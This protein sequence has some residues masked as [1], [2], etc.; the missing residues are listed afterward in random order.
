MKWIRDTYLS[1]RFFI[2]MG[3]VIVLFLLGYWIEA[4]QRLAPISLTATV[5][6]TLVDIILLYH[7]AIKFVCYRKC[8]KVLSLGTENSITLNIRSLTPFPLH[9]SII[10][11]L[12]EEL[13]NRTFRISQ[14][15]SRL[16]KKEIQYTIYPTSRGLYH[17]GHTLFFIR[18]FIGLAE[19]KYTAGSPTSVAVYPS[20]ILMKNFELKSFQSLARYYGIKKLRKI[21]HSY[22]FEQIKNYV[23]GDDIRS[24]NWKA[25]GRRN[26][27]M[28]NQYED[29][30]SQQVYCI[31]D[32]SRS[33]RLPF[34]GLTLLDHSINTALVVSNT[35]LQK[36][37][38]AGLILYSNSI[39][40]LIK[41]EKGNKQLRIILDALYNE[42]DY[43]LES[44][45][46]LLYQTIRHKITVRS[47]LFLFTNFESFQSVERVIPYL[48]K[49][50]KFHLLVVVFFENTEVTEFVLQEPLTT[51]EVYQQTIAKKLLL[52]KGRIVQE[53]KKYGIQSILTRPE[54]LPLNTINKYLELKS[55]G[56]I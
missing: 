31:I 42:S 9:L 1:L 11:E 53:L 46:E 18:S 6:L 43:F 15:F 32:K 37:D 25:T 27:I 51:E 49:I 52:E 13:E 47:L 38:K 16:E 55:R 28:V 8:A 48:R 34:N 7:K 39:N 41:A 35:A 22:E 17:F 12:P 26:E 30:K 5:L 4:L 19:R 14:L 2:L 56:M 3:I 50:N 23:R 10:D 20:L 21:G 33:M 54:D 24:I 40:R 45:M 36:E 44:N 29:E